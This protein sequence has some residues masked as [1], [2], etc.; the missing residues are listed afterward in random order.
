[1][2][3]SLLRSAVL[4]GSLAIGGSLLSPP[5]AAVSWNDYTLGD[6][7]DISQA[8]DPAVRNAGHAVVFFG[9]ATGFLI[10]PEGHVVTNYHVYQTFGNGGTVYVEWTRQGYRQQLRLSLV[11]ARADYDMAL[12]QAQVTGTPYLPIDASA[13]FVGEDVFAVGHPNGASQ[14]V[15][16][17]KVLATG[18]VLSGRPS[19]EYSTQT[20][21]GSSGSPICNRAG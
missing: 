8:T 16:F 11:V 13:P 12:Y 21:W 10:S 4:F 7:Y 19:I 15:S 9:N 18:H 14:E 1:M 2:R 6:F 3:G 20:W 5:A 17:G